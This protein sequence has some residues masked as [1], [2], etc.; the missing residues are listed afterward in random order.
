MK[1]IAVLFL[2][3]VFFNSNVNAVDKDKKMAL[4]ACKKLASKQ[5]KSD[6]IKVL[7]TCE[8]LINS[9]EFN[10]IHD[11]AEIISLIKQLDQGNAEVLNNVNLDKPQSCT[12]ESRNE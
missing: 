1:T 2:F 12:D 11:L 9:A 8:C 6:K 3:L 4:K 5:T 10:N 7:E